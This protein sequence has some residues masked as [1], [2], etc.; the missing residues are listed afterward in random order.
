[1]ARSRDVAQ[2]TSQPNERPGVQP[3][4]RPSVQPRVQPS[5]WRSVGRKAR[6]ERPNWGPALL[7]QP[8]RAA[9][10]VPFVTLPL[11]WNPNACAS[12]YRGFSDPVVPFKPP[13]L[14]Q[15]KLRSRATVARGGYYFSD[16]CLRWPLFSSRLQTWCA[17]PAALAVP[18]SVA[19][20]SPCVPLQPVP[21]RRPAP[22]TTSQSEQQGYESAQRD[23]AEHHRPLRGCQSQQPAFTD[24]VSHHCIYLV[25][26]FRTLAIVGGKGCS[27]PVTDQFNLARVGSR[28]VF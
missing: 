17:R 19:S 2:L 6:R 9:P 20:P 23:T 13:C 15:A 14:T 7:M 12:D 10:V 24:Y 11:H 8:A 4:G 16:C 3:S 1:M 22:R 21:P 27:A 18:Q 28:S 25:L 5:V 26:T